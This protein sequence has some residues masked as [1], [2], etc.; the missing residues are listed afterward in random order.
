MSQNNLQEPSLNVNKTYVAPAVAFEENTGLTGISTQWILP[1]D[2]SY[3]DAQNKLAQDI[4]T[5]RFPNHLDSEYK[6]A[7][8]NVCGFYE[9]L[10]DLNPEMRAFDQMRHEPQHI[11]NIAYGIISQYNKDDIAYYITVDERT[12]I[13]D[14]AY[15]SRL[16]TV[17][18]LANT[19]I[20]WIPAEKTL[21]NIET[22]L[23]A[24]PDY[25]KWVVKQVPEMRN[26]SFGQDYVRNKENQQQI[27][28]LRVPLHRT[29]A[30]A[31]NRLLSR[32]CQTLYKNSSFASLTV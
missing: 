16:N 4:K 20:H 1:E 5:L 27:W 9:G 12:R 11:A 2:Q 17:I 23:N 31:R 15:W 8:K 24:H 6:N 14:D 21:S 26:F 32:L 25:N 3:E 19:S 30:L 7:K 29:G 22:Q 13:T 28:A 10:L 18:V